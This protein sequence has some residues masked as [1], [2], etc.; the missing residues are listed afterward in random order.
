M[1]R[2]DPS[3]MCLVFVRIVDG[4]DGVS[5][6][7]ILDNLSLFIDDIGRDKYEMDSLCASLYVP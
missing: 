2:R 6:Y 5:P 7:D 1:P 4:R 3:K